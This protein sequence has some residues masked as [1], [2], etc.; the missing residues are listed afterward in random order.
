MEEF[1]GKAGPQS[2][3]LDEP[4]GRNQCGRLDSGNCRLLYLHSVCEFGL[5]NTEKFA[6]LSNSFS[7]DHRVQFFSSSSS[8]SDGSSFIFR[9]SS[10]SSSSSAGT[11]CGCCLFK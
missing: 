7:V 5:S 2:N 8:L 9:S 11:G 1:N 10:L 3:R 4:A 6:N